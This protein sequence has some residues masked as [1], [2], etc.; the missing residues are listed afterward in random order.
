MKGK[1]SALLSAMGLLAGSFVFA[2]NFH[3][4]PIQ[5]GFNADVIANGV[6]PSMLSTTHDTDGVDNTFVAEGF[7]VNA[8]ATPLAVGVPA[9]G[10]INSIIPSTPLLSYQLGNLSGN[11]ALRLATNDSGTLVFTNPVAATKLYMLATTGSSG[12]VTNNL[13]LTVTFTDNTTQV[14]SPVN[15]VDWHG[16]ANA[17]IQGINRIKRSTDV[18]EYPANNPRL[19]QHQFSLDAANQAKLIQSVSVT[20]NSGPGIGLVFAFAADVYSDCMPPTVQAATNITSNGATVNW[21]A[22]PSTQ[23]TSYSVYYST[24][25]T[26]PTSATAPLVNNVSGTSTS[27]GSLL[28]NTTYYVWVRSNCNTTTGQSVWSFSG[29]FKTLC[30]PMTAMTENFDSYTTGTTLPDCWVRLVNTNGTLSISSTTPASGTR[31]IYQYST[32][33]QNPTVAVLPEFSNVNAGTHWLKFNARVSS[34]TGTLNVG[35]VTNPS[36]ASTFV[37]LQALSLANTNYTSSNPQYTVIVPSTVP[38]NARLAIKN[39]A[40]GKSYYYDDVVWEP[41]PSCLPPTAVTLSA[42]T[43]N[44][45]TVSWTAPSIAPASGYEVYYSTTNTAPTSTTVLTPTNS[46]TSATTSA[47]L[48]SLSA[49]TTYYVWVRSKCSATDVSEWSFIS[50]F[51]TECATVT[52]PFTQT[53]DNGALPNCWQNLNP[54]TTGTYA[55]WRFSGSPGYGVST[56]FNG[57]TAGTYAWVDASSPY[58]GVHAVQLLTPFI[59]LTGL[60]QPYISFEW[61]KNHSSSSSSIIASTYADNKLIVEV[62]NGSGWVSLFADSSNAGQWRTVGIPLPASYTG[63]TIQVRFTVDK[64][65]A[66]NAY[67]YDDLLLDNIEVKQNPNLS[68]SEASAKKEVS[69]YPNPFSDVIYIS[70]TKDL[71]T[72]KVFDLT[73]RNVKTIENPTKEIRLGSL[74]SGLYLITMYYKDGSQNTVK[75]IKK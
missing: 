17:A 65:V 3:P 58:D 61:Y 19:Y 48:S 34:A 41:V 74:N 12:S 72:V 49:V 68:T 52:A 10:I 42:I 47:P 2:Q 69:V 23:A 11:N 64:D 43:A 57:R 16:G 6:G 37:L 75:A 22:S 67:F 62:N 63:T 1:Q 32:S 13:T 25:S 44:T 26:Q 24:S 29:S 55:F 60:T 30:G 20:K 31:N 53:F 14:F 70:E 39:T 4:M 66:G 15:V 46:T 73:G 36:D 38:S 18:I 9:N 33:S 40:D 21:A 8:S 51:T 45:A 5:S 27:V 71:K 56:T 50:T 7:Q 28:A 54:T 35:Y 59:D